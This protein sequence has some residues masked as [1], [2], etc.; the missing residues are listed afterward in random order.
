M[1]MLEFALGISIIIVLLILV[2]CWG[3]GEDKRKIRGGSHS[4][5]ASECM[6]SS[7][8][9]DVL[10]SLLGPGQSTFNSQTGT[11]MMN[12]QLATQYADLQNLGSYGDYNAVIQYTSLDP[13]VFKSHQQYSNDINNS[14][15]GASN[16]T[17]R[18]DDNDIVPWVGLRRPKYD[19]VYAKADARVTSSEYPASMPS[20]TNTII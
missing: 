16:L 4:R 2:S 13:S 11:A 20:S 7:G 8:S 19:Q 9:S 12:S 3:S 15:S 10:G 14:T 5:K 1:E 17:I 18:S 6:S